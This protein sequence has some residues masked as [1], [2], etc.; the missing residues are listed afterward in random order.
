MLHIKSL[1][2]IILF[3]LVLTSCKTTTMWVNSTKKDCNVGTKNTTCLQVYYG[4]NLDQATWK[5]LTTPIDRFKFETGYFQHIEVSKTK[6]KNTPTDANSISYKLINILEKKQDP[7]VAL[8]DIWAVTH[9]NANPIDTKINIPTLEINLTKM[10]IFGTD[11]CN[12][13]SGKIIA[14]NSKNITFGPVISTKKMCF[15]VNI[16]RPFNLSILQATTYKKEKQNLYIY[17]PDG[18]EVLRFKKVD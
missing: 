16:D 8:H 12:S 6:L 18:T 10:M 13:Y 15:D 4:K 14:L 5:N 17:N 3:T 2:I 9:I 1:L 11:G 7:K